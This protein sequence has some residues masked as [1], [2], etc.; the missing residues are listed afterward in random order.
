VELAAL[1]GGE[2]QGAGGVAV[3]Q[4]VEGEVLV[5][6]DFAA[7]DLAADHEHVVL[8][9]ALLG[10]PLA[11][12]AVLLL[13]GAVELQQILAGVGQARDGAGQVFRDRAAELPAGFLDGFERRQFRVQ[14]GDYGHR[15]PELPGPPR[16]P[17]AKAFTGIVSIIIK[18]DHKV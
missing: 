10:P 5:R 16:L 3:G 17:T 14:R 8:A 9:D 11:G 2:A 7:G 6:G 13:V 15:P 1:A 18:I 12:V 4:V